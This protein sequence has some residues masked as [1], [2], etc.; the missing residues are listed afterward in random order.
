MRKMVIA[1][2][3]AAASLLTLNACNNDAGTEAS[4]TAATSIDG[5]WKADLASVQIET[6]P[7]ELLLQDGTFSCST[8]TPAYSVAAD[9]AFHPVERPYADS[10]SV[11]VDDDHH[12]TVTAKK[13]DTV[14]GVTRYAVSEDGKTLT[15]EFNDTSVP[16]APPVTGSL[17]ENRASDGPAGSHA[18]SGSWQMAQY[19]NVSDEGLTFSYKVDGD[20]VHMST[21]GGVS[22]DAV[23]GGPAVP[24]TGDPAG[25]TAA[26]ARNDDGAYVETNSRDGMAINIITMTVGD[27]GKMHVVQ[28]DQRDGSKMTYDA[29]KS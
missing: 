16:N 8:C 21:P 11:K 9:G 15:I 18:L 3:L 22:Y 25:T 2:A 24:I 7:D 19:N 20:K 10:M 26:I 4:D 28:E 29:T 1:A 27:D 12:V 5:T 23:L 17:T 13:G 14:T 6:K